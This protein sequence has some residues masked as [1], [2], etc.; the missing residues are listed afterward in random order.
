MI[1][2][3]DRSFF[4]ERVVDTSH[5]SSLTA[6]DDMNA[7]AELFFNIERTH[8]CPRF[9]LLRRSHGGRDIPSRRFEWEVRI[10]TEAT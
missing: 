3:I 9:S 10:L 2:G 4:C 1:G 8:A 5:F 6:N 7:F